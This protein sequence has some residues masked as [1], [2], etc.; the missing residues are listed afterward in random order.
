MTTD[1]HTYTNAGLRHITYNGVDSLTNHGILIADG[2]SVESVIPRS[3]ID[4]IPQR[5]GA[6][7]GSR[8]NGEL[9]YEPRTLTYKF[10]IFADTRAELSTKEAAVKAWLNSTGTYRIADSNYAGFEFVNCVLKGIAIEPGEVKSAYYMYLTAV[11]ACDPY[12]QK[13]GTSRQRLTTWAAQGNTARAVIDNSRIYPLSWL[14][15]PATPINYVLTF[16]INSTAEQSSLRS[17]YIFGI[18]SGVT[19]SDIYVVRQEEVIRDLVTMTAPDR[20]TLSSVQ[21]DD[22]VLITYS[23]DITAAVAVGGVSSGTSYS[24]ANP[25]YRLN[26]LTEGT[27][28]VRINGGDPPVDITRTF[29]LPATALL[30]I[31]NSGYGYYELWH[32]DTEVRL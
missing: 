27:P 10:K 29:T 6:L 9:F 1:F 23:D 20:G 31:Y 26:A 30:Q 4:T 24:V 3:V 17:F 11:F 25:K 7:D 21:E 2:T 5:Q 18:P 12:M 14:E 13:T 15:V 22:M 16:S 19:V 8:V 32:D 28:T